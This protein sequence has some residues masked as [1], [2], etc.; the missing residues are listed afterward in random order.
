M[1]NDS[2][3]R[4][5]FATTTPSSYKTPTVYKNAKHGICGLENIGNTCFMNSAIQCISNVDELSRYFWNNDYFKDLNY[6]NPLGMNGKVANAY[7]ELI[8][9]LWSG[10]QSSF[11]PSQ[12]KREIA[13]F[14]PQFADFRQQD[15]QEFMNFLLDALH[16]D[17]KDE[18]KTPILSSKIAQLFHF[19]TQSIVICPYCKIPVN[20]VNTIAF[21]PLPIQSEISMEYSLSSSTKEEFPPKSKDKNE[22]EVI[23]MKPNGTIANQLKI[24]PRN[25]YDRVRDLIP[26]IVKDQNL[27]DCLLPTQIANNQLKN[28]LDLGEH[29]CELFP[30]HPIVFY[31]LTGHNKSRIQCHFVKLNNDDKESFFFRL[32]MFLNLQTNNYDVL[33]IKQELEKVLPIVLEL[34]P[35]ELLLKQCT[36]NTKTDPNQSF[37]NYYLYL[38]EERNNNAKLIEIR[39]NNTKGNKLTIYVAESIVNKLIPHENNPIPTKTRSLSAPGELT[40]INCIRSFVEPETIGKNGQWFCVYCQKLTNATKKHELLT[41]PKYLTLQLKRFNFDSTI[42]RKIDTFV[43]YPVKDLDL[44]EFLSNPKE[45]E[46]AIYDLIAVSNHTGSLTGGHYTT[47]AKNFLDH[48]WYDFNDSSVYPVEDEKSIVTRNAYLLIYGRKS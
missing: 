3:K 6:T 42:H 18:K 1:K 30:I 29:L 28:E 35:F 46:K 39:F 22:F 19:E 40:V 7:G 17:L 34:S 23:H 48:Q 31:E 9:N 25:S 32:P 33:H 26:L 43:K 45:K 20:T 38:P 12:L 13:R 21:L 41:L 14:A 24:V 47:V 37:K 36:I 8:Q 16:E 44:S 27:Y 10:K 4:S 11:T 2:K 5:S 15:S